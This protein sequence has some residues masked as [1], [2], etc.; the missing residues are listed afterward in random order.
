MWKYVKQY[1][2]F[3]VIA[4]LFMVGEVTMDLLQPDIMS[5][6]VDEGVLGI[7]SG[8][9]G[10]M[11]LI[12][13][14]GLM[15][16]GLVLFGGCCG[17]LNNVF[18]HYSTQN[19]GNEI[20]KDAF[21]RI[22][23]FSF[24]QSE[25]FG[26]GTLV[27][28][29]TNDITQIQNYIG[30]FVRGL[31]RTGLTMFGSLFFLFHLKVMFGLT[32]LIAFPFVIAVMGYCL[33]RG[34]PMFVVLQSK[35]DAVNAIMQED[36]SGIRVI[37]ACV[38]ELYERARF[39]KVNGELTDTQLHVLLIFSIMN[40][41]VTALM[42][43]VV[44]GILAIG[45][46][47]VSTGA[48]T[49]G[50]IMAAITYTTQLL[51]S[52]M[53]S[54]MLFQNISRGT[55]SWKRVKEILESEPE[56]KDGTFTGETDE[57]GCIEFRD[58]AFCY[59]DGNRNVIEHVDFQIKQGETVAIMGTTGCGKSSLVNLIPRFFDVTEGSVLVD[60]VDVREYTQQSLRDKVG[61]V[62]QKSELFSVSIAENIRWGK[63]GA[64]QAEVE[65]AARIAQ[66]ADF[67]TSTPDGYD[68]IVAERG[69]SLSGGQKQRLSIARA[70]LKAPEILIF[71]DS[72]SALDLKTEANF[73]KALG[74]ALP[75]TT[76]IIVAQRIASVRNADRILVLE[77]GHIIAA[78]SHGELMENCPSYQD[79]YYSQLGK[80]EEAYA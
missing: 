75:D 27:T 15:M 10:N 46:F 40:P 76:K 58:V 78:G 44:A 22:M 63:P 12:L 60:G 18:V 47:Q 8:G 35:L 49:P 21:A 20:R 68:T 30:M 29:V 25:Q 57:K 61:I 51:N 62:L 11:H 39:G 6:V 2:I 67:I 77:D 33:Y 32:A 5:R 43:L 26:S 34:N 38:R 36:V 19:M 48:V 70:V 54:T 64:A 17:S 28:R 71:D 3:A 80:E 53:N 55:A 23:K 7:G 74:E 45:H 66:A 9:V 1:L 37:K 42:Y 41:T 16:I 31:I 72:T 73:Y 65:E 24:S 56:Q 69:M 59:A 52:I 50:V 79:I 4:G 13:K 14:L